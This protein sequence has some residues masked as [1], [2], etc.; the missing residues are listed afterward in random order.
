MQLTTPALLSFVNFQDKLENFYSEFWVI[1]EWKMDKVLDLTFESNVVYLSH[2]LAEICGKIKWL[3]VYEWGGRH[4]SAGIFNYSLV[5]LYQ[6][7]FLKI[8]L[9]FKKE[10]GILAR[11]HL[12]RGKLSS[13]I[14]DWFLASL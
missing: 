13:G 10:Q 9:S 6:F 2:I 4:F 3:I 11:C 12:M 1:I 7:K 8:T 5:V 14:Q